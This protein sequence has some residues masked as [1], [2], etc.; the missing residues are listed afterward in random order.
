ML[1]R[2]DSRNTDVEA[3]PLRMKIVVDDILSIMEDDTAAKKQSKQ[4]QYSSGVTVKSQPSDEPS[5]DEINV[6]GNTVEQATER[7]DK[8]LDQAAVAGKL[9]VRIIHGHGTGA[10]CRGLAEFLSGHPLVEKI[11]NEIPERGGAAIT[12]VTLRD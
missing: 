9:G 5:A 2:I 10:S 4:P 3:G 6:I 12:L 11:T 7:V 1:R 8:F